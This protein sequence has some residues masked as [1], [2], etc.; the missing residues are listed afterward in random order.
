[1]KSLYSFTERLW[2]HSGENSAWHF[3][4]IPKDVSAIIKKMFENKKRGWGSLRVRA[5]IGDTSWNTSIF[6]DSR[7]G[8]YL[9][10]VKASVRKTEDLFPDDTVSFQ[11]KI[12]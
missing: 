10:P 8:C 2:V 12:L 3:L 5:T 6:P 9:L 11:I 7:S 1:M 4:A